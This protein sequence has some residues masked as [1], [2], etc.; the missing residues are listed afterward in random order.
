VGGVD[1]LSTGAARVKG[2]RRAY[3]AAGVDTS[4]LRTFLGPPT[5]GAGEAAAD[6]ILAETPRPTAIVTGSAHVTLGVLK[7]LRRQAIAVPAEM[8]LVGFGDPIWYE[9][10]GP[11]ITTIQPPIHALAV[12]CALWFLDQMGS[13]ANATQISSHQ[14]VSKSTLVVRGSTAR[15]PMA[16]SEMAPG[17]SRR[18]P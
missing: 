17:E 14:A 15:L 18:S 3:A 12:S 11:G 6:R 16:P 13:G 1:R 5:V 4:M 2:V 7:T 9:W 10:W 8:S